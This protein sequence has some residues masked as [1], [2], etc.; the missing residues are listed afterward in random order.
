MFIR[1]IVFCISQ[2]LLWGAAA[3]TYMTSQELAAGR[4]TEKGSLTFP[5]VGKTVPITAENV[6]TWTDVVMV[7]SAVIAGGALV[8]IVQFIR[9]VKWRRRYG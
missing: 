5:F 7:V 2:V 4:V 6:A 9:Y 8:D 1:A 3:M